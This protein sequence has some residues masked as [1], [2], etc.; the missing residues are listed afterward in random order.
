MPKFSGPYKL[1]M[2]F[3]G[4]TLERNTDMMGKMDP[5]VTIEF[6]RGASAPRKWR[7]PTHKGGH[8]APVWN[9]DTEFYYGGD[10]SNLTNETIK[11]TVYEEDMTSSDLVA[12]TTPIP[13]NQYIGQGLK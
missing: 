9:W 5:F 11:I 3:I 12:E 10:V 6:F 2:K 7:G 13:I 8:K 4:A 1:A